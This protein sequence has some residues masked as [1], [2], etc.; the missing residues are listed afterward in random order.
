M[1]AHP[2]LPLADVIFIQ[3]FAAFCRT[4]GDEAYNYCRPHSCALAQF[5]DASGLA[6]ASGLPLCRRMEEG[7]D[8]LEDGILEPALN[9]GGRDKDYTF[10]ALA[11]RLE[12]LLVDAPVVER[13]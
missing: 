6:D 2:K 9:T 1:S 13:A 8:P 10:S 3:D 11:D 12:A 4:K 7:F 5:V